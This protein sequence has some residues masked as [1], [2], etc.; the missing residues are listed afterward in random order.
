MPPPPSPLHPQARP[1]SVRPAPGTPGPVR[2]GRPA[3]RRLARLALA[4]AAVQAVR[5]AARVRRAAADFRAD[6]ARLTSTRTT[7][8]GI[9][10]SRA[11]RLHA[12]VSDAAPGGGAPVVLVH[13]YAVGSAYHVPLA[14]RLA[15]HARVYAPDL[16]GHGASDADARAL[17]IPELADAL[18]AWMDAWGLRGALVVGQSLGCQIAAELAVRHRRLVAG[19]VLVAPTSDPAAPTVARQLARAAR[20]APFEPLALLALVVR[21]YARASLPVLVGELRELVAHR[22]E[23]VLPRL[24]LPARVAGGALD[25][26]VP[27]AGAER[28][29]RLAGAPAPAIVPR[30]AHAV[31]FEDPDAV[32]RVVLDMAAVLAGRA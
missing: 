30:R 25:F 13:G 2:Q 20:T 9:A 24:A 15:A 22:L 23:D 18:A 19:L 4:V 5:V 27:P 31:H 12:R 6:A 3:A 16:P 14:A 10:G 26:V 8:R 21:D 17:T 32:A 7:V 1:A 11:L 28:V 29:A